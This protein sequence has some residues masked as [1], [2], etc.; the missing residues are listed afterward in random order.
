MAKDASLTDIY[1]TAFGSIAE[2]PQLIVSL[3]AF[4]DRPLAH[5]HR[6]I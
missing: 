3:P 1:F 5:A 6:P 4:I 2:N